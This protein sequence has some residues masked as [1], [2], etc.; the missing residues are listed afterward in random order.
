MTLEIVE[1]RCPTCS[2]IIGEEEYRQACNALDRKV[3]ETC[4]E[5]MQEQEIKHREEIQ[6]QKEMHNLEFQI[7]L[8]QEVEVQRSKILS[9]QE[10]KS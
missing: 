5:K 4:K 8:S 7:R 10:A 3:Q 1:F 9:E 6:R 2:H